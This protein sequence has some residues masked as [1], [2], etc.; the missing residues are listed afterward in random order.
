MIHY[1]N[2]HGM[3]NSLDFIIFDTSILGPI[4]QN[5]R[6]VHPLV[7]KEELETHGL[8]DRLTNLIDTVSRELE[9]KKP[10][11]QEV[12][13]SSIQTFWGASEALSSPD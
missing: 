5:P 2:S 8:S 1:S 4:F 6:F 7:T 12:V 13:T 10:F 9:Q 11:Y 3:D